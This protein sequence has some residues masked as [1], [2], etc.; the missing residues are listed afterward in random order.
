MMSSLSRLLLLLSCC[1]PDLWTRPEKGSPTFNFSP[2][3]N[4]K[5]LT[6][7]AGGARRNR[8]VAAHGGEEIS[9]QSSNNNLGPPPPLPFTLPWV[10]SS[11]S[12]PLPPHAT[13]AERWT[14]EMGREGGGG[15][16]PGILE[17]SPLLLL[18][19]VSDISIL[20]RIVWLS[21]FFFT[22]EAA[23]PE[24]HARLLTF[25]AFLAMCA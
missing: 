5:N 17:V 14:T 18:S 6:F 20:P 11:P 25:S 7:G 13:T 24:L 10:F 4:A 1:V 19:Q 22:S 12:P 21:Y 2:P 15:G 8:S 16:I 23:A 9:R 3:Q